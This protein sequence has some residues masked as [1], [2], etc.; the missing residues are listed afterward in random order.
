MSEA[1][2]MKYGFCRYCGGAVM[3]ETDGKTQDEWNDEATKACN[4]KAAQDA[5]WKA[6]VLEDFSENIKGLGIGPKTLQFL[7]KGAELI[8]DNVLGYVQ[9]KTDNEAVIKIQK[10]SS[11][12]FLRK[13]TTNTEELLSEGMYRQ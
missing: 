13:T 1:K 10:K 7:E 9:I 5:R 3:V 11:G 4:C 2:E 6:A 8:A 12:I